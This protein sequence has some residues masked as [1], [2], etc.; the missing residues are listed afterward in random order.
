MTES[1]RTLGVE[2]GELG[3]N[4]ESHEYPASQEELVDAYGEAEIELEEET[5]TFEDLISPLNEDEYQSYEEVEGAIMNMVGD[6]A[7]GRK[8]YSDRTP[9]APG[10]DRQEEGAPGQDVGG[11]QESF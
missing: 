8:N 5:I 3:E 4:L 7:I 2:L 9:Y 10:E 11:D 1:N 6:D